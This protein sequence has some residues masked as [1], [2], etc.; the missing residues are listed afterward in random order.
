MVGDLLPADDF[1]R[2]IRFSSGFG[3]RRVR[4]AVARAC[5]AITTLELDLMHTLKN[6]RALQIENDRLRAAQDG[7]TI[8]CDIVVMGRGGIPIATQAV[9]LRP[10]AGGLDLVGAVTMT[11]ESDGEI[12]DVLA[13]VPALDAYVPLRILDDQVRFLKVGDKLDLQTES[14]IIRV[15]V[16]DAKSG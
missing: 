13:M 15:T 7:R 14:P 9:R 6:L 4:Q 1:S 12:S 11:A 8:P 3:W 2:L 5:Y 10:A 16:G